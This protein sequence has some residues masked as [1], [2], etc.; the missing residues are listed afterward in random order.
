MR[1]TARALCCRRP[2][3][4]TLGVA[5][6]TGRMH[7]VARHQQPSGASPPLGK[8]SLMASPQRANTA[9]S[10]SHEV[11]TPCGASLRTRGDKPCLKPPPLG[12][13]TQSKGQF[14]GRAALGGPSSLRHCRAGGAGHRHRCASTA[15]ALAGLRCAGSI[16]HHRMVCCPPPATPNRSFKGTRNSKAARP[17]GAQVY[18]APHGRAALLPRAP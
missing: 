13:A 9:R 17:R 12:V 10:G 18:H 8:P 14:Y 1:R 15:S 16:G 2:V 4:S 3:N 11:A 7:H 6:N 5:L